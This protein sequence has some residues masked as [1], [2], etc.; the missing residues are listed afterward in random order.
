MGCL[1]IVRVSGRFATSRLYRTN[2]KR[3]HKQRHKYPRNDDPLSNEKRP[4]ELSSRSPTR[5]EQA[6][7]QV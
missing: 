3:L 2:P 1:D 6:L 7:G 5:V 4:N